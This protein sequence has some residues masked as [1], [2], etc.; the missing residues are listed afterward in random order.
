MAQNRGMRRNRPHRSTQ[1]KNT[2]S[3]PP[4]TTTTSAR[5]QKQLFRS[6]TTRMP[7]IGNLRPAQCSSML[8]TRSLTMEYDKMFA[9]DEHDDDDEDC[10]VKTHDDIQK[11]SIA[12]VSSS[13]QQY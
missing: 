6:A 1:Y 9:I 8:A 3:M 11:V 12:G 2:F 5:P 13:K 10:L 7:T 4:S